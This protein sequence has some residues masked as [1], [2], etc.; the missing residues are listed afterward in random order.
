VRRLCE[1]LEAA[2]ARA[3]TV[4]VA[5]MVLTVGWQVLSRLMARGSVAFD[6]PLVVEPS[7]WTEELAGFQL[8]WLAL[9]GAVYA[10]RRREH[11]GFD[12][13][14]G[15]L[16]APAR[17]FADLTAPGLVAAFSLLV[18]GYGGA[19]LVA[20]T[21]DLGQTTP[22]LGWPMGL[23]YS[24]IPASGALMG[25]FAVEE[26]AEQWRGEAPEARSREDAV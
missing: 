3:L 14:H 26:L 6:L 10:L 4:L 11:P 21:L 23:V 15:K 8:A 25:L 22:A 12:L 18:L 19:R 24:V 5:A 7:R 1:A 13:V 16:P 17:R 2:L 9:L 20:M